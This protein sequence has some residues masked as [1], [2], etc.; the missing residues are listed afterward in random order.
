VNAGEVTLSELVAWVEVLERTAGAADGVDAEV[1]DAEAFVG[2]ELARGV[3][4]DVLVTLDE[5]I[6]AALVQLGQRREE[7]ARELAR[8]AAVR[9]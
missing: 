8:L 3:P 5:R 9:R 7:S 4:L 2:R 6:S 1:V